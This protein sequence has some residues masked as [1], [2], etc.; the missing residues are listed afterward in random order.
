MG[1]DPTY[2]LSFSASTQDVIAIVTGK[3]LQAAS[4]ADTPIG[5]YHPV[6]WHL[7]ELGT[8]RTFYTLKKERSV[9][10]FW[11]SVSG[12]NAYYLFLGL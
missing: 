9:E 3:K 12:T 5:G 6:W 10:F 8:N 1:A 4:E 7:D 11:V 2:H